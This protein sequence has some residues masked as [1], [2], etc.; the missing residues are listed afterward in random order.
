MLNLDHKT[1]R[2][3][4]RDQWSPGLTDEQNALFDEMMLCMMDINNIIMTKPSMI[5][6]D[7]WLDH[8]A[9]K[10]AAYL[11]YKAT[12]YDD[13]FAVEYSM[14][15]DGGIDPEILAFAEEVGIPGIWQ[16]LKA[17]LKTYTPHVIR[18]STLPNCLEINGVPADCPESIPSI[19]M[20]LLE[21][22]DGESFADLFC[23][24]GK[25]ARKVKDDCPNSK[26]YGFDQNPNAIALAKIHAELFEDPISYLTADVFSLP[27]NNT[28]RPYYNKIYAHYPLG[29]KKR[30]YGPMDEYWNHIKSRIPGVSRATSSDWIYNILLLNMLDDGG[31]AVGIMTNGSTWNTIDMPIRKYFIENGFIE[32]VINLPS[33]LFPYTN[34]GTSMVVLSK[35]N[36]GI[37]LVDAT[38][39]FEAGRRVNVI[40]EENAEKIIEACFKD[41]E[42]SRFIPTEELRA[43]DYILSSARYLQ[44]Q[45]TVKDGVVFDE[46]IKRITRGASLSAKE[47]DD[48]SSTA[49]TEVQ[50]LTLANI[51]NGLIDHTLPYLNEIDQKLEKYCLKNHCLILSKNGYP[52]KIAVAELEN[53]Q[54]ILANG[55]L[56]IIETD[57]NKVDPY[58][59]IAFFNSE[60]GVAALKSITVGATIPNIGVEQLK[61]LTIPL[62]D[63]ETQREVA[64]K[65]QEIKDEIALLQFK[66]EKARNRMANVIEEVTNA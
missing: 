54:K 63:I 42:I 44:E 48:L 10:V 64:R 26:V 2:E 29:L 17:L 51:H 20:A 19:A 16:K 27:D 25:I 50:Y 21:M 45:V 24:D 41:G 46:I 40:T 53:K 60:Q 34:I 37:R 14:L 30:D 15:Q 47:L 65:Y 43:N 1:E 4:L 31:K 32:T 59:L 49:P 11:L 36:T 5:G 61:K 12:E 62:P 9:Y 18:M 8:E 3:N 35:G 39:E 6:K 58:Y 55:N 33:K 66:L 52:Y 7:V 38:K 13:S 56:Y 57:E 22:K 23:G 28:L